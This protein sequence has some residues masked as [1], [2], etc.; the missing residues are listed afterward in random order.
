MNFIITSIIAKFINADV[1]GGYV[2]AGVATLFGLLA[3]WLGPKIPFISSILTPDA[4]AYIS[5]AIT[6]F[7]VGLWSQVSKQTTAPT[8]TQAN[9]VT[10]NLA[11]AG[12]IPQSTVATVAANPDLAKGTI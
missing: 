1:I 5:A 9:A 12:V 11:A 4:Q 2:R 8:T 7:L 10:T 3:A 6:A